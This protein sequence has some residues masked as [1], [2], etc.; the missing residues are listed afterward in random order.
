MV[1]PCTVFAVLAYNLL[2][3]SRDPFVAFG[4][5]E[6]GAKNSGSSD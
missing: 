2:H 3:Q 1:N 5:R 6:F 4:S